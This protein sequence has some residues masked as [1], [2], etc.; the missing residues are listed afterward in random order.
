MFKRLF[1]MIVLVIGFSYPSFAAGAFA[2]TYTQNISSTPNQ[3]G[4]AQW[5][6]AETNVG[7]AA[8]YDPIANYG[9]GSISFGLGEVCGSV[10]GA[11]TGKDGKL[12]LPLTIGINFA[13]GALNAHFGFG[14]D[15]VGSPVSLWAVT[16]PF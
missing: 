3:I 10:G 11:I 14:A 1:L 15:L 2:L 8:C 9:N 5:R 7:A 6:G 16:Y 12:S 13:D 4:V